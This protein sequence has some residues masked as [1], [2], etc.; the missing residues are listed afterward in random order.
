MQTA[1][2]SICGFKYAFYQHQHWFCDGPV[3]CNTVN[4]HLTNSYRPG[5]VFVTEEDGTE[6][7]HNVALTIY[8]VFGQHDYVSPCIEK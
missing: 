4:V 6:N 3:S 7:L 5:F 1:C 8:I 2:V